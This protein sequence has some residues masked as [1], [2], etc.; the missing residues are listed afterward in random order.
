MFL[1]ISLSW[2]VSESDYKAL[3]TCMCLFVYVCICVSV[4]WYLWK[5]EDAYLIMIVFI[6]EPG[7]WNEKVLFLNGFSVG[8]L[9]VLEKYFP[10]PCK[11]IETYYSMY[12][13]TLISRIFLHMTQAEEINWINEE[14]KINREQK[15]QVTKLQIWEG[16]LLLSE[17]PS[18]SPW[19][20][21]YL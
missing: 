4:V 2:W 3:F 17:Q 15:D 10:K 16:K 7:K 20:H 18:P 13:I 21:S 12:F 9:G 5:T 6:S 8:D 11:L 14:N 19:W 1:F